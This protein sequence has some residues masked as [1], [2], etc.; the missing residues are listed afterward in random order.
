MKLKIKIERE[1]EIELPLSFKSAGTYYHIPNDSLAIAIYSLCGGISTYHPS[2]ILGL[3]TE[4]KRCTKREC[5]LAFNKEVKRAAKEG[6][7]KL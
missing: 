6:G 3:F 2:I 5:E 7:F 1:I 4:E